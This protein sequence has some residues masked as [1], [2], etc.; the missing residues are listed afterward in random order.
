MTNTFSKFAQN[1]L[2]ILGLSGVISILCIHQEDFPFLG[3]TISGILFIFFILFSKSKNTFLDYFFAIVSTLA[4]VN[5]A[6]KTSFL[7]LFFSFSSFIYSTSWLISKTNQSQVLSL[8]H[9]FLPFG[10]SFFDVWSTPDNLPKIKNLLQKTDTKENSP[11][12][13]TKENIINVT[14]TFVVLLIILP[15]LS[16]SNPYFGQYISS[17]FE[18][19][20]RFIADIFS[21]STIWRILIAV[22]LYS[23]LPRLYCH[24]QKT[25]EIESIPQTEFEI[26]LPK[27]SVIV[28]LFAFFIAQ[29]QT[30][31]NP[32]LLQNSSGKL[33]NEIFFHLSIVCLIVFVLLYINLKN[34][35]IAKICSIILLVQTTILTFIA[36][37]SDWSYSIEWGLTHKRLYGFGILG[38]VLSC[39]VIFT[40]L[41]FLNKGKII[42]YLAVAFCTIFAITNLINFDYFIYRNPPKESKGIELD[43]V[44]AM[45]LD[46]YS[47]K[48]EYEKQLPSMIKSN[49]SIPGSSTYCL[50]DNWMRE[51][52]RKIEYLQQKYETKYLSFSAFNWNEYQNYL[53]IKNT[54]LLYGTDLFKYENR[55]NPDCYT[56]YNKI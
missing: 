7:V 19:F 36:F 4:I 25:T 6:F 53:S 8:L 41:I 28:T 50:N 17:I 21:I 35:L 2:F 38:F 56:R 5:F 37:N 15:L 42:N 1:R 27:I 33:A 11:K 52:Y 49:Q 3:W 22:Y 51:N 48:Q 32:N 20:F 40:I 44:S 24:C 14:I 16:Y 9:L 26:N 43:Y 34:K 46:S 31:F 13:F 18:S 10:K 12:I 45:N 29:V 55:N 47:L 54:K 23:Y 39:V 30:Y